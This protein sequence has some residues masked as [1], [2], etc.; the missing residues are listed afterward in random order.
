MHKLLKKIKK[1]ELNTINTSYTKGINEVIK[2]GAGKIST[3]KA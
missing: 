2:Y 1:A 3:N